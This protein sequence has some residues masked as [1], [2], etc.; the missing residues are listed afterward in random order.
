MRLAAQAKM[1]YYPTPESVIPMIAK[2]LQREHGGLVR[3]LDPCAGKGTD[4]KIIGDHLKAETYGIE[5]DIERGRI[6]KETLT[7]CLVTDYRKARISHGSFSL[8]YLNPPYDFTTKTGDLDKSERYERTFLRDCIRRL[9][10]LG[11]LVYLIPQARLD[12]RI[13]EILAYRFTQLSIFRFPRVE[14]DRFKQVVIFGL[15]KKKPEKDERTAA[16]LKEIGLGKAVLPYL[17]NEPARVYRIPVSPGGKFH[18]KSHDI[19]PDE[20]AQ[21]LLYE[22]LFGQISRMLTPLR[23]DEKIKPVM[24]LRHG[25]L[26]QILACGLMNGVVYDRKGANPLIVKGITR[27][28]VDRDVE[29]EGDVEKIIETDR[30]KI[31]IHA[32]NRK[33]ELLTIQ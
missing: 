20:L 6:A 15:L 31:V 11:V 19:D 2:H 14:F 7:R 1:G 22:G 32:Y 30:I 16:Y 23:M 28:E 26:A 8:L 10:T 5:L 4:L 12:R 33:G 27:K 17:S 24:P 13:S 3:I 18:F 25:H 21:E 9:T 29:I